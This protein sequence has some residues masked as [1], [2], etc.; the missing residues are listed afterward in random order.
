MWIRKISLSGLPCIKKDQK[1]K[2]RSEAKIFKT[3]ELLLKIDGRKNKNLPICWRKN[4]EKN[5]SMKKALGQFV[6]IFGQKC[7]FLN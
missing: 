6:L 1:V 5:V 4:A 3:C 2:N 7:Q